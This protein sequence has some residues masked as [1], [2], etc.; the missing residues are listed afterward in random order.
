MKENIAQGNLLYDILNIRPQKKLANLP[1]V[2]SNSNKSLA[3][4]GG[5]SNQLA[6]NISQSN[7]S[8]KSDTLP[9][10]SMQENTNNTQEL[11]NSSFSL[12]QKQLE[13]I[14]NNNP[15]EDDYHT[16]IRNIDDIKTFEETLEDEDYKE[17]YEAGEDFDETYSADIAKEALE[18]GKITVYSSYPIEQGIFVT[19][20]KMEASQYAGGD[21][22]KV[23]L[24][25][26][27]LS[28]VAW[29]DPTQGQYAKVQ[30][31]DSILKKINVSKGDGESK[32]AVFLFNC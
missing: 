11:D 8:V 18:T 27:N 21:I 6:N 20:S 9:K 29:L 25:E 7:K 17:Y 23:Y 32:F 22:N 24:K 26:V 14:K 2:A 19:P 3:R 12:K 4:F 1:P 30:T 28:D 15:A 31:S 10:Y 16:W 5:S 13:I